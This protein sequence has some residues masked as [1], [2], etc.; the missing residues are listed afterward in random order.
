MFLLLLVSYKKTLPNPRSK[1]LVLYF[2]QS[3]I[4]VTFRSVIHFVTFVYGVRCGSLPS[5]FACV[6]PV[7]PAP[8]IENTALL[9]LNC[10]GILVENQL[11]INVRI[12]YWAFSPIASIYMFILWQYFIVWI[13]LALWLSFQIGKC[14]CSVFVL[15]QN[16][17]DYFGSL[18]FS[19]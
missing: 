7:A 6:Y 4:A 17:F 14:E 18:A 11:A 19:L 15:P 12:Y 8:F 2:L 1:D 9:L 5:I 16:C 10:L 13:T 3:F